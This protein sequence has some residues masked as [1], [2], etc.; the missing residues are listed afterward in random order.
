MRA[1]KYG[2]SGKKMKRE[3]LKYRIIKYR[4]IIP[5]VI[6]AILFAIVFCYV[7]MVGILIGFKD[8]LN[9]TRYDVFEAFSRASWTL[10]HF[11]TLFSSDEF[12]RIIGNTLI[13]SVLKIVILFPLPVALAIM[14]TEVKSSAFSKT[15]QSLVYLPHFLSWAVITG[16]FMTFLSIDGPVNTILCNLGLMDAD[17]P[18]NWFAE[19][20]I[21]RGLV[22]ALSGWKEIGYSAIVYIAAIM[23]ID[24]ALFEAAELD[25]AGK[26]RRIFSITIPSILP[27]IAVLLIIRVGYIMD[28]GFDQVYTMLSS[29]TRETGE[30]LGT[31]IY[32][33][34]MGEGGGN[35]G[36]S[37]AAGLFNSVVALFFVLSGNFIVKKLGGGG[38]W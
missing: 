36:L 17:K 10:E 23:G 25:G 3:G 21:F 14:I 19:K 9:L 28:A 1:A 29:T 20:G 7:P 33:L 15:V 37:T 34:G 35:Y 27:T 30:I 16:I 26:M 6:P 13:I 32:R 4:D 22:I 11:R 5:F 18:L 31:Y 2:A 8:K 38:M 24:S 12:F